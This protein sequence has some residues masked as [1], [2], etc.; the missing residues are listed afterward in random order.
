M[1][2]FR[3]HTPK[4]RKITRSV[5]SHGEHRADLKLDF[6][7]RCGYCN[8]IDVWRFV[9]FEIDHFIPQKRNKKRFLT[10]KSLTDYCNLVYACRSCNNA[11]R[12]KWPSNDQ[13]IPNIKNQGFID[14]CD[15]DYNKQFGRQSSGR[16]IPKTKLGEWMYNALKLYKPQYEIIWNIEQ[17]HILIVELRELVDKM[18]DDVDL[19]N[20]LIFLYNAYDDYLQSLFS[21]P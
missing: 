13:N 16:I 9:W 21:H 14:P 7:N 10:I 19:K 3:K 1:S 12:N 20:R 6:Q 2:V 15:D 4:R 5:S 17:L 8:D 11:K 18:P